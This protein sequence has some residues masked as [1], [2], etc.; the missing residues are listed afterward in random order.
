[1]KKR[2]H[3]H[4]LGV[5][6]TGAGLALA[7]L[8][9]APAGVQGSVALLSPVEGAVLPVVADYIEASVVEAE[10]G[11]SQVVII[12]L[13]TPGGLDV[14]MREIVRVLL[15]SAIPT[16]VYVSPEVARAASA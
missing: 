5:R 9:A 12:T 2:E 13:D 11:G 6:A 15:N 4:W 3:S 1:M 7:G 14:S 10:S 16:V 8:L